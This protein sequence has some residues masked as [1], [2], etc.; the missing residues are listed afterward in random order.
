MGVGRVVGFGGYGTRWASPAAK[1]GYGVEVPL[2]KEVISVRVGTLYP[3]RI[4]VDF[5]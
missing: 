3:L 5:D 2:E 4:F 1:R